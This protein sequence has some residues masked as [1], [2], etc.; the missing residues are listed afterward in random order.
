[1]LLACAVVPCTPQAPARAIDTE[2]SSGRRF[3]YGIN[4]F[5]SFYVAGRICG[6]DLYNRERGIEEQFKATGFASG[7]RP[8]VRWPCFAAAMYPLA[9]L[10]YYTAYVCF[11]ALSVIA[12]LAC[13]CLLSDRQSWILVC[14]ACVLSLPL[15]DAI[16]VGQDLTFVMLFLALALR[17]WDSKPAVAGAALACCSL[18]YHLFLFAPLLLILAW[19]KRL[20]ISAV[21]TEACLLFS[22]FAVAGL[23]WPIKYVRQLRSDWDHPDVMP[24]LRAL[25]LH[26][27]H[28]STY[29]MA[30]TCVV[31]L[32]TVA[33]LIRLR[34]DHAASFAV[35]IV[36]ALLVTPHAYVSDCCV[37]IPPVV[38]LLKGCRSRS[39]AAGALCLLV[40]VPY[41]LRLL[42]EGP[43][44]YS[45]EILL[46][47]FILT[48]LASTCA[49]KRAPLTPR[50]PTICA[51][52]DLR[53]T[54]RATTSAH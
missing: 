29:L 46:L 42:T 15:F 32:V 50:R 23:D 40:P 44:T 11:Q 10:P 34:R 9:R 30:L 19:R 24:N 45:L 48:A 31:V 17:Y 36:A 33:A 22:S 13:L 43:L 49:R 52:I 7:D 2:V 35:A 6:P 37:L 18:K 16:F 47:T 25:T 12:L 27:P 3:L 53:A 5:V 21:I 28:P 51:T 1:M 26:S 38:E 20:I 41:F 4:D 54:H 8:V 14:I 39:L